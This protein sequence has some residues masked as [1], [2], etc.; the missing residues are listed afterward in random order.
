MGAIARGHPLSELEVERVK[1]DKVVFILV[2][3]FSIMVEANFVV[4]MTIVPR[5]VLIR[6]AFVG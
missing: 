6:I 1:E 4:V 3:F 2:N 5:S